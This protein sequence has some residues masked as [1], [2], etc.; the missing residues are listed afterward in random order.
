MLHFDFNCCVLCR[1]VKIQPQS[2]A[3]LDISDPRAVLEHALRQFTTMSIGDRISI[4]YN[5]RVYDLL[6]LEVKPD[7]SGSSG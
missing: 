3:F 5:K 4:L 2:V 1:F 7:S 6:V